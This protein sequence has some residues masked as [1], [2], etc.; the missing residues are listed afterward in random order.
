M[1]LVTCVYEL[2]ES[3]HNGIETAMDLSKAFDTVP[4]RRLLEKLKHYGINT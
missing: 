2:L 4:H 1:Q 3:L